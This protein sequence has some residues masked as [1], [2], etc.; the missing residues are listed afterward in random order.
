M[1]SNI[2]MARATPSLPEASS[3]AGA[4]GGEK[5]E[6]DGVVG[7]G[8][9]GGACIGPDGWPG[10]SEARRKNR[11]ND[12]IS[13]PHLEPP[14]VARAADNFSMLIFTACSRALRLTVHP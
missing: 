4:G 7:A 9:W 10:V 6:L 14:T 1:V 5:L 2:S 11:N 12:M 13:S 3:P 8:A